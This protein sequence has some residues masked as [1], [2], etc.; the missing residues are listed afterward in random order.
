MT[1]RDTPL[2]HLRTQR[3]S[4]RLCHA[5]AAL[6]LTCAGG[7]AAPAA[8]A[9][10]QLVT[11]EEARLPEAG[12]L[13]TRAITRGPAVRLASAAEVNAAS[14][15]LEIRLEARGGSRIEPSTI[16]VE[17]LKTP[18]IDLTGRLTSLMRD[19]VIAAPAVK[20]PAGLH[21]LRVSVQDSEGRAGS[22]VVEIR[23]R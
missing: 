19:N 1:P 21:R 18:V 2:T 12:N 7:L 20:V 22:A 6:A 16:K 9:Q 3:A 8:L 23:A 10:M 14:F 13:L 17:Y 11:E 15:P 4:R 5:A